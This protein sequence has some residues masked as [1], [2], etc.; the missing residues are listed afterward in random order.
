MRAVVSV[1]VFLMHLWGE[2]YSTSTYF[3]TTLPEVTSVT[4]NSLQTSESYLSKLL[5][6][7]DSPCKNIGVGCH[8]LWI[9]PTQGLNPCLLCLLRWQ[10]GSLPLAPPGK[11]FSKYKQM[12]IRILSPPHL[13]TQKAY[14]T[15]SS[16][17][18]FLISFFYTSYI[19][20]L[21]DWLWWVPLPQTL[22]LDMKL[23]E[24]YSLDGKL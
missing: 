4:S 7:W 17:F 21:R 24:S 8:C 20:A 2:I 6:P 22:F 18:C 10:V 23:K 16:V 19:F 3:S 9:F 11:L 5:C 12:Q 15:H 1:H 13:S 14:F